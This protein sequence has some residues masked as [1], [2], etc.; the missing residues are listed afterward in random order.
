MTIAAATGV[1]RRQVAQGATDSANLSGPLASRATTMMAIHAQMDKLLAAFAARS[2][3]QTRHVQ[4][5]TIAAATG[6]KSRQVAQHATDSANLSGPLASRATMVMAIHA[7]MD[8][9]LA[10]F[11]A[12]SCPQTR[13]VQ[14]MTIVCLDGARGVT[15]DATASANLRG[16]Q[17]LIAT[18]VMAIHAQMDKV[19]AADAE[20]NR[21]LT[22]NVPQKTTATQTTALALRICS[23]PLPIAMADVKRVYR[24]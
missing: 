13:H 9:V 15:E 22:L 7:Q 12:R 24:L 21:H 18:M 1:K 5:M 6:V 8:K 14:Q 2:C 20:R 17:A 19:L 11:A 10:V 3:P 4:Q 16:Q 23:E